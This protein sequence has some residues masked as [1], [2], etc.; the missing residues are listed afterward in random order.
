[1]EE[2]VKRNKYG[3]HGVFQFDLDRKTRCIVGDKG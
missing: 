1:M 3:E 2:P